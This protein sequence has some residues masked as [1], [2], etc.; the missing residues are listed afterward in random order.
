M[1]YERATRRPLYANLDSARA[2]DAAV[3]SGLE[4]HADSSPASK[5]VAVGSATGADDRLCGRRARLRCGIPREIGRQTGTEQVERLVAEYEA[6]GS[7]RQVAKRWHVRWRTVAEP[8]SAVTTSRA[9]CGS[10]PA[11]ES[12]SRYVERNRL[13]P[14]WP[15]SPPHDYYCSVIMAKDVARPWL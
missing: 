5:F 12:A 7:M 14:M 13:G 2:S 4:Q 8:R 3:L 1:E 9:D 10:V 6:G 15:N 11:L